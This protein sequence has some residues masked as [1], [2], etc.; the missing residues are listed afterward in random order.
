MN[1]RICEKLCRHNSGCICLFEL[2]ARLEKESKT[3]TTSAKMSWG[4][5]FSV[6]A[7]AVKPACRVCESITCST[8]ISARGPAGAVASIVCERSPSLVL[9]PAATF[10]TP[11]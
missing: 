2:L 11:T 1:L 7:A 3:Q 6:F 8:G 10:P 9:F 4:I 5:A